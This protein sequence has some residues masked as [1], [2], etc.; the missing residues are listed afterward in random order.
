MSDKWRRIIAIDFDGTLCE[1]AW[2]EI[3]APKWD[4]IQRAKAEQ[5]AGTALILWTCREGE[6]L[7]NALAACREWGLTFDAVNEN[8]PELIEAYGGDCRKVTA[9]EYWDDKAGTLRHG[10][11]V[12]PYINAYGHPCHCCS[13]CGFK[14][15]WQD[16]NF[17]P[18]CGAIMD[19]EAENGTDQH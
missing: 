16:K 5:E 10:R 13:E 14:A 2:P 7:E 6:R 1:N 12:K 8:L 18:E 9:T 19:E 4:I 3:G 11:W 15:S 17:C